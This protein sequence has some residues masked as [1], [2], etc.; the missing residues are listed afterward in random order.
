MSLGH[1]AGLT[2]HQAPLR[3]VFGDA[4]GRRHGKPPRGR[5]GRRPGQLDQ[6]RDR[7]PRL[8]QAVFFNLGIAESNLVG[9]GAG[10]A[11]CGLIPGSTSFSSFLLC[12]AYDQLRLAVAMSTSTPKC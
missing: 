12:N 2:P 10:L 6:S 4:A 8:P 9:V 7:P 3:N 11:A 5:A 1:D